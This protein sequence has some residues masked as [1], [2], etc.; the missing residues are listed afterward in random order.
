MEN[1]CVNLVCLR[2]QS[3][4]TAVSYGLK[5]EQFRSFLFGRGRSLLNAKRPDIKAYLEYLPT[6]GNCLRTVAVGLSAIR[7]FYKRLLKKKLIGRN[8]TVFLR[9]KKNWSNEPRSRPKDFVADILNK[10]RDGARNVAFG[11]WTSRL[12]IRNWAIKEFFYGTAARCVECC[13]ANV[14]DVS[15][16]KLTIL[17][18]GKGGKDR[19]VSMTEAARDALRI[20]LKSSRPKLLERSQKG[21]P[22]Q[23]IFLTMFGTRISRGG[24]IDVTKDMSS[25]EYRHSH[26]QHGVD[27]G[28]GL[29]HIQRQLGHELLQTTV[30]YAGH[31]SFDQ[32]KEGHRRYHPRR[33][34][35]R[36][37]DRNDRDK[38]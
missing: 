7:A 18:H 35:R 37:K 23:A 36:K 24:L 29:P 8:P 17:L 30:I 20:Y 5:L 32:L 22:S 25:H 19:V 34:S 38:D 3:E 27:A 15:M 16:E 31:V 21:R 13:R 4:T 33:R 6:I 12:A 2:G 9:V 14:L 10:A 26:A 11:P 1:F 28:A